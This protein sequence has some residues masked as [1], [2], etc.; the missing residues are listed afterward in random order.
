MNLI[1]CDICKEEFDADIEGFLG[2]EE[3]FCSDCN[4]K[5]NK[6]QILKLLNKYGI[7]NMTNTQTG[8]TLVD[9]SSCGLFEEDFKESLLLLI[10]KDGNIKLTTGEL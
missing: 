7:Y 8:E 1:K 9:I 2:V 4:N 10:D 6:E 5:F 3:Q